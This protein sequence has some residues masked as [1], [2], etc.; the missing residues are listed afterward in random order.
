MTDICHKTTVISTHMCKYS[1]VFYISQSEI[2]TSL[3][4]FQIVS[5]DA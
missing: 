4:Q 2:F 3:S 5:P 1:S